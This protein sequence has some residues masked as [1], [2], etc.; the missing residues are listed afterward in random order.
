MNKKIKPDKQNLP[1]LI[2]DLVLHDAVMV[3]MK[4]KPNQTPEFRLVSGDL[5]GET[6][7]E[8][9]KLIKSVYGDLA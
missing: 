1:Y 9:R 2:S 8:I 5:D 6:I 3:K 7:S 4:P